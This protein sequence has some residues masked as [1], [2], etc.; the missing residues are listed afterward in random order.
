[1]CDSSFFNSFCLICLIFQRLV[2]FVI[3]TLTVVILFQLIRNFFLSAALAS[4][5]ILE[6]PC[7]VVGCCFFIVA[8]AHVKARQHS[9]VSSVS[10]SLALTVF[11]NSFLFL[12]LV[13]FDT[14]S[15]IKT[16]ATW[17][18]GCFNCNIFSVTKT[19]SPTR[20]LDY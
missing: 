16:L 17:T 10:S 18:V 19:L 13:R 5:C 20:T 8:A 2:I 3:I 15:A 11:S 6:A 1:M 7:V 4:Y 9:Y 12:L 14:F